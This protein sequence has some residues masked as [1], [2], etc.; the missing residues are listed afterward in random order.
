MEVFASARHLHTSARKIRL[1]INV[2]RGMKVEQA[3]SQLK[4]MKKAAAQLVLKLLNSAI[5]NATHNFE[6]RGDSLYIKKIVADEGPIIGRW[7]PRAFGRSSPIR[8]RT[9]H[10]SI[11]LDELA[12]KATKSKKQ[13][14]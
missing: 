7:R 8:K 3:K 11:V 6:L 10:L 14:E 9:T 4:F 1:V 13:T 2:I 12:P 5:A